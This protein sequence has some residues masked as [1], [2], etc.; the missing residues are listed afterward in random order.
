MK[1][2]LIYDSGSRPINPQKTILGPSM[3]HWAFTVKPKEVKD[4]TI[5]NLQKS[6]DFLTIDEK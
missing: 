4:I 1:D 6:I 2:Y 5:Q 3:Y